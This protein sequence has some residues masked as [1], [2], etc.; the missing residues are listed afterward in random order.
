MNFKLLKAL[1]FLFHIRSLGV[2]VC[3]CVPFTTAI[4]FTN[5]FYFNIHSAAIRAVY[6]V[7]AAFSIVQN[8]FWPFNRPLSTSTSNAL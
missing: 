1:R 5:S 8:N 4:I 7:G 6:I 2:S 3:V